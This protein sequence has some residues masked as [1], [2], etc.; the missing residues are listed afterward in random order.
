MKK[1]FCLLPKEFSDYKI[2]KFVILPIP[3]EKT[4][5]YI[6]GTKN[7][8]SAIIDASANLELYDEELNKNV[9]EEFGI[10]T[11]N[12]IKITEKEQKMVEKV[13]N[14]CMKVIIDDK[15]PIVIG[16]EHSISLGEVIAFKNKYKNFSVLQLDAHA[17]LRDSYE[18]SIYSHACIMRRIIEHCDAVQIGIRSLS[19]EEAELIKEKNLDVFFAHNIRKWNMKDFAKEILPKLKKNVFITVDMDFFDPSLIPS[20]GTPE[21]GGFF[22]YETLD[23]LREI[24]KGKN[25]VGFDVVEL[26]PNKNNKSSEFIAAKFIY[27]LVNFISE[28]F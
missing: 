26:C 25:I 23:F 15:F 4:T 5:T 14:A 3:Y 19:N 1:N 9:A 8:P 27:K 18:N 13:E 10:A 21:P 22:W 20:V 17:D 6:K 24:I 7:A 11:L 2:A 16:G 28:N 12:T